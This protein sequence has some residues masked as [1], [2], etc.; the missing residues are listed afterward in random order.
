MKQLLA[1]SV[2]A[3]LSGFFLLDLCNWLFACGCRNW[4]AGA[5]THCN[6][7]HANGPHCPWCAIG[8]LSFWA[9]FV[10]MIAVQ[11]LI[12]WL[13]SRLS[14]PMRLL[15]ALASFPLLGWLMRFLL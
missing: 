12:V 14:I 2:T 4:L 15:A 6:I 5:V 7:H 11:A 10:G 13:P 9:T 3:G 8:A 1:L